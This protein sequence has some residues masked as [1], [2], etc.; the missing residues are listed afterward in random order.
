[1]LTPTHAKKNS[2]CKSPKV[3]PCP[4]IIQPPILPRTFSH[5]GWKGHREEESA[6]AKAWGWA[7]GW[8]IQSMSG[9]WGILETAALELGEGQRNHWGEI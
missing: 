2:T 3:E 7:R 4:R 8:H 1:M 9:G 6:G 5:Q